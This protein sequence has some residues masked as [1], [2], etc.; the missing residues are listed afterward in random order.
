MNNIFN[1]NFP[2]NTSQKGY[3]VDLTTNSRD[4]LIA[5][6]RHVLLTNKGTRYYRPSFG[7]N[8]RKFLFD[9]NDE[10]T[11]KDLK[12]ELNEILSNYFP[13]VRV[14]SIEVLTNAEV[15]PLFNQDLKGKKTSS[16]PPSK[17]NIA[18]VRISLDIQQGAFVQSEIIDLQL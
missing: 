16:K 5:D 3:F 10:L 9:P 4:G 11:H 7:A 15:S 17:E 13:N 6:I 8:L 1:V 2:I 18:K 14:K 12:M